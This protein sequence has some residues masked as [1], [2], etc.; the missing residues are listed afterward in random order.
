[1]PVQLPHFYTM[2]QQYVQED[3]N[4]YALLSEPSISQ[5]KLYI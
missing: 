5:V 3:C 2:T 4:G 1:L